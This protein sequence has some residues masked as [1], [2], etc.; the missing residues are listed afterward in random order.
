MGIGGVEPFGIF[1]VLQVSS[2]L[3]HVGVELIRTR[4]LQL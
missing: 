1:T 2:P 4:P 3:N